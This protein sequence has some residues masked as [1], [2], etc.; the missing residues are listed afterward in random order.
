[1]Q[2][3]HDLE[4]SE[5]RYRRFFEDSPSSLWEKDFSEIKKYIDELKKKGVTDF[6]EYFHNNPDELRLCASLLKITDIKRIKY[7][8]F[9]ISFSFFLKR[10]IMRLNK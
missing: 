10:K 5:K 6:R 4:Q 9:K 1:M 2:L 8:A 3:Q 7:E